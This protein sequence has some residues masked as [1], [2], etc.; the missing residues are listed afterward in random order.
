MITAKEALRLPSAQLTPEEQHDVEELLKRID[1]AV[2]TG[3]QHNGI[4]FESTEVRPQVN[5]E[6][7]ARLRH[8]GWSPQAIPEVEQPRFTGGKPSIR[9]V[10][11]MLLPADESYINTNTITI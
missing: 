2:R 8:A 6:V 5:A 4:V 7:I 1:Q 11:I 10:T 9:K 3:M